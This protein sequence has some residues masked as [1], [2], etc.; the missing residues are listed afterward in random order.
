MKENELPEMDEKQLKQQFKTLRW[1]AIRLLARILILESEYNIKVPKAAQAVIDVGGGQVAYAP[2]QDSAQRNNEISSTD[3]HD[4]RR[5]KK[6]E[7]E[8]RELIDNNDKEASWEYIRYMKKVIKEATKFVKE[9]EKKKEKRRRE[10]EIK[11]YGKH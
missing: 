11:K 4:L 10:E 9:T 3:I 1:I 6:F 8:L 2:P 7:R 5:L